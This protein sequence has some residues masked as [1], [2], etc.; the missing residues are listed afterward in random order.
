MFP[1]PLHVFRAPTSRLDVSTTL[2]KMVCVEFSTAF[3]P[4]SFRDLR[5]LYL[6]SGAR[7]QLSDMV[8]MSHDCKFYKYCNYEALYIP[9]PRAVEHSI[10]PRYGENQLWTGTQESGPS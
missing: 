5:T 6:G 8:P 3:E 1:D 4:R 2:G 7:S 9:L 10:R